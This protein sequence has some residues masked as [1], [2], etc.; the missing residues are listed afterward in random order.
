[1][2]LLNLVLFK[3]SDTNRE[4]YELSMQLMQ[5]RAPCW[6]RDLH[7]RA[8][9]LAV[10]VGPASRGADGVGLRKSLRT[11]DLAARRHSETSLTPDAPAAA[12]HFSRL[13]LP[14]PPP[15]TDPRSE[16]V[17]LLK[18]GRRAEA[19]QHPLRHP[20]PAAAPVQRVPGPP[21]VRP[22]QDVP[23]AHA[24]ALLRYARRPLPRASALL[25]TFQGR[26]RLTVT[27]AE[28]VDRNRCGRSAD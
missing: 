13:R 7:P 27:D 25:V 24:P 16:A 21:V 15:L 18:E 28:F 10:G 6:R 8:Q 20:R 26:L 9:E 14:L 11:W 4:T 5:A 12:A 1:M 17:R 19:G 3:A 2:T 23:R 22:G